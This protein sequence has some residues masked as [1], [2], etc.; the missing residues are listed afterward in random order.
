MSYLPVRR[1]VHRYLTPLDFV[2][3]E[4]ERLFD[5]AS[6]ESLF[7]FENNTW[8]PVVDLAETDNEIEVKAELPGIDQKNIEIEVSNGVLTIHGEKREEKEEKKKHFHHR[9]AYY[10]SFDRTIK[11]PCGVNSDKAGASFKDGVLTINLPKEEKA[12]HRKIE[13]K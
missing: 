11:L 9:E 8:N 2:R 5:N 13:I 1:A 7:R 10:G 12:L 3:R 4:M 6:S